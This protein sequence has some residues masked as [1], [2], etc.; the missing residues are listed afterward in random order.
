MDDFSFQQ[1]QTQSQVQRLS[2]NLVYGLKMLQMPTRELRSEIYRVVNENPALEIVSDPAGRLEGGEWE[3]QA[4][5]KSQDYQALLENREDKLETL[6][7][8]LMH[9]LNSMRLSLDEYELSQ[10]LIYNLDK[11]GCYGSMR[12]PESLL[13]KKRPLQ[14]PAMLK[15]CI[16]RIQNMDP[17]GTCCKNLEESLFVQA[18]IAGN[19]SPLTL[20]ILD[21]RLDFL[22][23]P[24]PEKVAK[25]LKDF[26]SDWKGKKFAKKLP[27][28]DEK[29]NIQSV[30]EAIHYILR[31]N[32]HPASDYSWEAAPAESA[33]PDIV[34]TV[35]KEAGII[36]ADDFASGKIAI[37]KK[38]FHFQVKYAS[39]VLP[40]IRLSPSAWSRYDRQ[41]VESAKQFLS[42][43]HFRQNTIV[44]QGCAIVKNQLDFFEK[45]PGNI[46]PLTRSQVA[47]SLGIHLSTVSRM[48]AKNNS[49][50]IQTEFGLFPASYFFSSGVARSQ[51]AG[52]GG[53]STV[54]GSISAEAVKIKMSEIL[55]AQN[56]E[57]LSDN[58]LTKILNESGIKIARRTVAKYRSQLGVQNSYNRK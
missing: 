14:T 56:G 31:L 40:E 25:K 23:P 32:P 49:K 3:G 39:G 51:P 37:P 20:F 48:S 30:T 35:T 19:A 58:A 38:D 16:E 28:E 47:R 29:I 41:T 12:A 11:N 10:K 57:K 44:L 36:P 2:Q 50:Y 22:N 27:V 6:Q 46:K 45:G 55:S 9:Q 54:E 33:L 34:L 4:Q 5:Y 26:I 7:Q 18:K 24:E 52:E 42:N 43:I 53:S 13:D 21:G 17:V 1:R 15:R 8:H